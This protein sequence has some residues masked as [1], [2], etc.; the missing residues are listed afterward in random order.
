MVA[1]IG[2]ERTKHTLETL[3]SMPGVDQVMP[4]QRLYKFVSRE[5]N[6]KGS[7][8]DILG[9]VFGGKKFQVIAGPCSVESERQ[10]I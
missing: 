3:T 8:V 6:P 5:A 4:V 2:D 9:H 7:H 10:I 1:A